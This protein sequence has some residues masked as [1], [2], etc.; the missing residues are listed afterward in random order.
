MTAPP[1]SVYIRTLNEARMIAD[2]IAA[3]RRVSEDIVVVDSGSTDRT[4]EI[5]RRA[6]ARVIV[7][8]WLGFGRQKRIGEEACRHDYVLDLDADE[9]ITEELAGE[10]V[11][12]FEGGQPSAS[13]YRT[14]MQ[15]VH[16]LR[17]GDVLLGRVDRT[18]LYDRRVVRAPDHPVWDQFN[19]PAGASI[20]VLRNPIEHH[21]FQ[22]AA[23][24][25]AKLN[26]YSSAVARAKKPKSRAELVL[27]IVFGLPAYFLKRYVFEGLF[28][29]GVYGFAFSMMTAHGR[30]LRDV[31][32][33]ELSQNQN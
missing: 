29:A 14:P 12:L 10:I 4:V 17:G 11:G 3:A 7:Q 8:P 30:W 24:L 32:M 23:H 15:V 28:R 6:G 21:A 19:P 33:F 2:T 13:V 16:R 9:I 27:R 1:L 22:D 26:S 31:K 18:K 20:G 25:T 5:A